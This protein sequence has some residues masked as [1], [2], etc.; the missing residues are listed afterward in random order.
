MREELTHL[1]RVGSGE[2]HNRMSSALHSV[3]SRTRW[4]RFLGPFHNYRASA[5]VARPELPLELT[6]A[7]RHD[8]DSA[9]NE[10]VCQGRHPAERP[11]S[12][13][14]QCISEPGNTK[15]QRHDR[16]PQMFNSQPLGDASKYT[17]P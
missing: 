8:F 6:A 2:N 9:L 16:T 14:K 3:R 12:D 11:E 7:E 5:A 13:E 17:H 4:L 1:Q 10:S 15:K